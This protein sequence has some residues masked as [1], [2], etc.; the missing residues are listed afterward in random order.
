MGTLTVHL[1]PNIFHPLE[2]ISVSH[3]SMV[4]F[5][6]LIGVHTLSVY[7]S[8]LTSLQLK[9]S[10]LNMCISFYN[11]ESLQFFLSYWIV[12]VEQNVCNTNQIVLKYIQV[13]PTITNL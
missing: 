10:F 8:H 12:I 2:I 3:L 6:W 11:V 4:L 1:L 5:F 9:Y 13:T 7:L